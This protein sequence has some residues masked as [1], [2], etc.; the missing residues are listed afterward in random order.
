MPF[1]AAHPA[2]I[3]PLTKT[4]RLSVTA[5]V[6]GSMVPDFE[7]FFQM[8]EVENIG[9]HWHGI[10]LFDVPVALLLSYL[11]HNL[12][13][14]FFIAHLPAAV[15][16]RFA[17]ATSFNWHTYVSNNKVT[18]LLSLLTGIA[19]H[20]LLDAF[21]HYDGFFVIHFPA[22]AASSNW[23]EVPVYTVLQIL[24]SIIGLVAIVFYVYRIPRKNICNHI[25]TH[26]IYWP[27]HIGLI[28]FILL[29]RVVAWPEYNTF[30]GLAIGF[31]GSVTYGWVFASALLKLFIQ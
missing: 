15:K 10:L 3:L 18:V 12:L 17:F 29:I 27:L 28:G 4:A 30:G 1:T 21:T 5:L 14:N 19:S 9:H 20:M 26:T 24:F 6:V 2:I 8:R 23:F 11:F 13:R 7:F 31:M 16:H 22:L 25:P